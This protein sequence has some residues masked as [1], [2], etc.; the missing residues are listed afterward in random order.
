MGKQSRKKGKYKKN[1][2]A[3]VQ[4]QWEHVKNPDIVGKYQIPVCASCQFAKQKKRPHKT[5][6]SQQHFKKEG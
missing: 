4:K 2:K 6:K 5:T 3:K 1:H